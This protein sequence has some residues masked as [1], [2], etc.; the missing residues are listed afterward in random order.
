MPDHST[1]EAGRFV[2]Q[3]APDRPAPPVYDSRTLEELE[4]IFGRTRLMDLLDRLKTEIGERLQAPVAERAALGQ[5]AHTLLSVSGS[6]GFLDLSSRCSE[7]E[8]ACLQGADL[9]APLAAAR[10]SAATAVAA[11]RALQ[12]RT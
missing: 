8:R 6:L 9:T 3:D 11:I 10:K 4:G 12:D 5:D 7:V 1:R 2:V